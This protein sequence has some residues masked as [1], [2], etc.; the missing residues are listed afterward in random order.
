MLKYR[1]GSRVP[2]DRKKSDV[3]RPC[4]QSGNQVVQENVAEPMTDQKVQRWHIHFYGQVQGVGFRF[5]AVRAAQGR[6][7][8]GWVRN[9]ADRDRRVEMVVEGEPVELQQFVD[10]V[11]QSTNGDV[12]KHTVEKSLSTGEFREFE[13]RR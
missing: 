6:P 3:T 4:F 1:P 13:I 2:N 5:T 12:T 10:E 7:V 8:A 11:C 9:L